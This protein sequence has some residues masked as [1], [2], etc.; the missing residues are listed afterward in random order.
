MM[1]NLPEPQ[2]THGWSTE[3][4]HNQPRLILLF[5]LEHNILKTTYKRIFW[6]ELHYSLTET[7]IPPSNM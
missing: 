4:P 1:Q 7:E 5:W 6:I 3:Q 2:S